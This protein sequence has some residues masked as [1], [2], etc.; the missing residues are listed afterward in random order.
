MDHY[1]PLAEMI[2]FK[3]INADFIPEL[4][5]QP[6]NPLYLTDGDNVVVRNGKIEKMKGSSK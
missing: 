3:G 5:P 4:L 6:D 1:L 2:G